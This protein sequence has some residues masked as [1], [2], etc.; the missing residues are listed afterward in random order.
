MA[1]FEMDLPDEV[2]KDLQSIDKNFEKI[3]GGMTQAGAKA[4][5]GNI[6]E[7]MPA[8]LKE[9]KLVNNL[10]I[11][12][13]YKTPTDN[14]INSKVLFD[15]YFENE[16]G[17]LTPAPLVVNLFEYGTD[18]GEGNYPKHPFFR[19]SFKKKQ[20]EQAMLKA[21]KELSGGLLE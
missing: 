8:S 6:I 7:N 17:V 16:N 21:Q 5:Y 14:A 3:F 11:S 9:S 12:K 2:I 15:G 4:V 18:N 19:K 1:K 20:I 10:K 13:V